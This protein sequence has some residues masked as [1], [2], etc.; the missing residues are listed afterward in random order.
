MC[1]FD[2]ARFSKL[3]YSSLG[4]TVKVLRCFT[5]ERLVRGHNHNT[6]FLLSSHSR[7]YRLDGEIATLDVNSSYSVE[8]FFSDFRHGSK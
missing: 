6:S 2:S 1:V 5:D 7:K 8:L 4:K 3:S